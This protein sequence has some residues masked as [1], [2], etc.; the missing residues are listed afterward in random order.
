MSNSVVKG[1]AFRS[2]AGGTAAAH[3]TAIPDTSRQR[4]RGHAS[5]RSWTINGDFLTLN[6][7]GV[8]RYARELVRALDSLV[9]EGHPLTEGLRLTIVSPIAPPESFSLQTIPV[10]VV[11]EAIRPHLPQVWVQFQLPR[12]V[13]DGLLS[14]CNLAPLAVSRQIVCIHD[15]QTRL[16]PKSYGRLFRW[17]HRVMLPLLGRRV[18][19][20]VTVSEAS[21]QHLAT[22]GV[23]VPGKISVGYNGSDHALRW[24]P[25]RAGV[26]AAPRPY[27][28]CIGRTQA[29][30]NPELVR[31]IAA[32]LDAAG[33][34]LA[35]VGNPDQLRPLMGEAANLRYL[36]RLDDDALAATLRTAHC[37]LL[38]SRFEGFGLPAVEAMA[39][40]CPVIASTSPCL[41]EICASAALY[42]DPEEP[43][44]WVAA[45]LSLAA[46]PELRAR[47]V[48]A[49]QRRVERFSWRAVAETYLSLM[50]EMDAGR[51]EA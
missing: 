48:A 42:A 19:R 23:A 24:Q 17:I 16:T 46:D 14:F 27:V 37:L 4:P 8:A 45:I 2:Y 34:D 33:F 18:A 25:D 7:E 29:H 50:A 51:A 31:S 30:K 39:W 44:A 38:P 9:S 1:A 22:Y 40:N 41:P 47:L 3:A 35:V 28:L 15:L 26:Q 21:R 10:H 5:T 49:G 11:P 13:S 20:I 43:D 36:G 6:P 12:H 32:P